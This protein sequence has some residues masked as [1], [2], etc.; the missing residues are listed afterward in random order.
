M[1]LFAGYGNAHGIYKLPPGSA[2]DGVKRK[3]RA[4]T[5][6]NPVTVELWDAHLRGEQGLGV[7]PI[8]EES[9]CKFGAIDVDEYPL[10]LE[11]LNKQI[12]ND[13]LPLV[14]CRTKSGGAHLYMF[15]T[16]FTD[17]KLVQTRLRE[18]AAHLGHGDSEIY[19]RQAKILVE[20]GDIG[21]WINMP[22]F[23]GD[24]TD[25][26]ALGRTG[27]ELRTDLF[28]KYAGEMM[29]T[30]T[31]LADFHI[32]VHQALIGGPPCLNHLIQQG[33]P[34]GTRNNGL[35]NLAIYAK[36]SNPDTWRDVIHTYNQK[37]MDPPLTGIEVQAVT[38]S[39]EKKEYTYT[40]KQQPIMRHCD[41]AK[42]RACKFGI[43][44]ADFG[45]P[46]VGTLTKL[47]TEPPIWF[48][49]V[50]GVGRMELSTSD[51]Q[52]PGH[53]QH[54]CMDAL[55]IMPSL[56]K[57]DTWQS[58]V[59]KL[60]EDVVLIEVP[61]EAT[62]RGQL[63]QHLEDFCT[64]RVQAKESDEL[65]LGKPWLHEK[66]HYFRL[67]DFLSYLERARF[68][69]FP[70]NYITMVIRDMKAQK[71]FMNLKGRGCNCFS[72]PEFKRQVGGHAI[73]NMDEETHF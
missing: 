12:I 18:F 35:L 20:R 5:I 10:A 45:M 42:C 54:R 21:Q 22:Y 72:I 41:R 52:S 8:N 19:P 63:L 4:A 24:A 70:I 50:E 25:R 9:K 31:Q 6:K 68:K 62:P 53:F 71:H 43:G 29:I 61:K 28:V 49:E 37:Y 27:L 23:N 39:I 44:Q 11:G 30:P 59:Q 47:C 46:K 15:M 65:L 1:Q 69:D 60:L 66:R 7:I 73:P 16:E 34:E 40:C 48:L 13:K 26:Y 56:P 64:N 3:G 51:L 57:R 17:A 14:L 58:I 67:K 36:M 32:N 33:F 38:R 2:I 55:N